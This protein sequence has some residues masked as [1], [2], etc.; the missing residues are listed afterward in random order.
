MYNSSKT[1]T[2]TFTADEAVALLRN[3]RSEWTK[4]EHILDAEQRLS[5]AVLDQLK[6]SA[7]DVRLDYTTKW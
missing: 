5:E 1:V 6:R 7:I 2:V 3:R 4:A